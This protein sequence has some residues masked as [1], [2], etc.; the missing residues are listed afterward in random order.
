MLGECKAL[1]GVR[2][3]PVEERKEGAYAAFHLE[4]GDRDGPGTPYEDTEADQYAGK[5]KLLSKP[6]R[7]KTS[8]V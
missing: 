8:M 6:W 4:P 1:W 5:G 2:K 3:L 7:L